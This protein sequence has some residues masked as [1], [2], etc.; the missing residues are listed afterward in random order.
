[1][2]K[3]EENNQITLGLLNAVDESSSVTQRAVAKELGIALGL[4]NTYLKRCVKKGLIKV[5]QVPANRYAYY[6]TPKGFSEKA[7]LT[8]EYL[9]QGFQLFRL[10]RSQIV[11]IMEDCENQGLKKI[12]LV[13]ATDITEIAILCAQEFDLGISGILVDNDQEAEFGSIRVVNDIL[14]LEDFDAIILTS[15]DQGSLY[16]KKLRKH[17][18]DNRIFIPPILGTPTSNNWEA[19]EL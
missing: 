4:V 18:D 16:I 17:F 11:E 14:E 6:L 8:G 5:S 15:L 1:M 7:R 2:A 12:V 10:S 13:G 3:I 9:S 19:K